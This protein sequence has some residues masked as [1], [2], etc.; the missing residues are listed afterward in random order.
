MMIKLMTLKF[1]TCNFVY[2]KSVKNVYFKMLNIGVISS[3][4]EILRYY[5]FN[6]IN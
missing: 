3:N 5:T 1:E 6:Y 4:K 2:V